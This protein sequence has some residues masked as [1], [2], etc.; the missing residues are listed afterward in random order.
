MRTIISEQAFAIK[1]LVHFPYVRLL[2]C[3]DTSICPT[4]N[5]PFLTLSKSKHLLISIF[6]LYQKNIYVGNV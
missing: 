6:S 3:C 1:D 4:D 5:A 2:P